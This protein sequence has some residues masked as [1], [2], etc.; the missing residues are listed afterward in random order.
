MNQNAFYYL[1][2]MYYKV[3]TLFKSVKCFFGR[4]FDPSIFIKNNVSLG[5]FNVCTVNEKNLTFLNNHF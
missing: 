1:M 4:I 2:C 3:S 5:I